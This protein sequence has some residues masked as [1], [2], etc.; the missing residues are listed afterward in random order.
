MTTHRKLSDEEWIR[1]ALELSDRMREWGAYVTDLDGMVHAMYDYEQVIAIL[2]FKRCDVNE[3][4][5]SNT[6]AITD[7]GQRAGV[8]VYLVIYT[9]MQH[10]PWRF[11]VTQLTGR[12]TG[13]LTTSGVERE[14]TEPE[15]R[16]FL[17][18]LK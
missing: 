6:R 8:P 10:H 2:E 9:P 16:Q 15:W 17:D 3:R 13:S 18:E 7:L 11:T 1:G 5:T 4:D 12:G 14:L